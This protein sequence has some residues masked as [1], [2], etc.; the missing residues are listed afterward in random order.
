MTLPVQPLADPYQ[1]GVSVSTDSEWWD[2]EILPQFTLMSLHPTGLSLV[3]IHDSPMALPRVMT[4]YQN[5]SYKDKYLLFI[6]T[7][8]NE[9]Q[10]AFKHGILTKN[11]VHYHSAATSIELAFELVEAGDLNVM[12]KLLN[13]TRKQD[14]L[15]ICTELEQESAQAPPA[16]AQFHHVRFEP[17]TIVDFN[18]SEID[19]STEFLGQRFQLPL[20]IS[21]MTGGIA[22]GRLINLILAHTAARYGIPMSVGSQKIALSQPDL[23]SIFALK[24]YVDNLFLIGNLGIDQ[25]THAGGADRLGRCVDMIA[26]D[27]MGI[28]CNLLQE[29]TQTEGHTTYNGLWDQLQHC[30]DSSP[31]PVMIKEV[32]SGM[33]AATIHRL[34][35]IGASAIDVGGSGG[36]SWAVV[37]SRRAHDP[38]TQAI[39]QT[40]REWGM[41]T[42][43][44]LA[45]VDASTLAIPLVATGGMRGGLMAAQAIRSGAHMVGIGMPLLKAALADIGS[46]D[47]DTTATLTNPDTSPEIVTELLSTL[48]YQHLNQALTTWTQE[49]KITLMLTGSQNLAQLK[50]APLLS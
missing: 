13:R 7:M 33:S 40:F 14:H 44:S 50:T 36:L 8:D 48:S 2:G 32:G 23:S 25:L 6:R 10:A 46:L 39:G 15:A 9:L 1:M 30:L 45:S 5:M 49:L 34:A 17:Q 27:A 26:A 3:L 31:V 38:P 20:I 18:L 19:L 43:E 12:Q 22:Q 41:S 37:E 42:A 21:A 28:H 24:P 35:E 16:R 4:Y 47:A 29:L 11:S